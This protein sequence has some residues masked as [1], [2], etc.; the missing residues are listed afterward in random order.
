MINLNSSIELEASVLIHLSTK[1]Q[2]LQ[3]LTLYGLDKLPEQ[4]R[5]AVASMTGSVLNG[6]APLTCFDLHN[7]GFSSEDGV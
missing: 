7:V 5:S 4:A 6:G 2:S 3:E 1:M